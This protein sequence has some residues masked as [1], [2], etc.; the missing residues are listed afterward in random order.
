M[1]IKMGKDFLYKKVYNKL[2]SD[3][4]KNVYDNDDLLPSEQELCDTFEV[5]L[6][7]VR[8]ALNELSKDGLVTK[9]RGKGTI[10]QNNFRK[11]ELPARINSNIAVAPLLVA[12]CLMTSP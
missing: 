3:I 7:T 1:V 9:V 2:H 8:R 6:I 4:I 12:I 5:S 10:V 11:V